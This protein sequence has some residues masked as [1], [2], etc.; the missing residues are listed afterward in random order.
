MVYSK[1]D[2]ITGVMVLIPSIVLIFIF[3]YGFIFWSF[4]ISFSSWDSVVPNFKFAGLTNYLSVFKSIRFR[5]DLWNTFFFTI[6]FILI[7]LGLGLTIALLLDNKVRGEAF[8]RSVYLFPMS[9]SFVVTGIAWRWILSPNAGINSL[10][11]LI[12]INVQWKWFTS[13]AAV[14]PFNVAILSVVLPAVWQMTGYVMAMYLAAIK[15]IPIDIIEA[16]KI[17][18][19][20]RFKVIFSIIIPLVKPITVAAVIVLG[21]ISLKIF[22][23]VYTMTG[24]GTGFVTDV[25]GIYMFETTF[26]G[27]HYAEGAVISIVMLI[28]IMSVILPYLLNSLKKPAY[29]H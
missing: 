17:D 22:D 26:R 14:G 5:I 8:F 25:P 1:R 11:H 23:L 21:H 29:S 4:Y 20:S 18:G 2:K 12:D 10:L 15:N 24:S 19:A 7:S 3:V 6:F 16:A 9:I 13:Q 27:N 28:V